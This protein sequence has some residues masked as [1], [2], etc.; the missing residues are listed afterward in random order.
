[1]V[2]HLHACFFQSPITLDFIKTKRE[3]CYPITFPMSAPTADGGAAAIVCSEEF[4]NKH[5][6]QVKH[7]LLTHMCVHIIYIYIY[8]YL[9]IYTYVSQCVKL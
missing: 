8:T 3:L 2:K 5:N 7:V 9:C 1:M 4:V 6:L